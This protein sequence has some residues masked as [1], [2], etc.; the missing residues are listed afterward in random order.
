MP[1]FPI[2]M[3]YVR[4]LLGELLGWSRK[5]VDALA[6]DNLRN[7]D[8]RTWFMHTPEVAWQ[9]I[10][11]K[12]PDR[13]EEPVSALTLADLLAHAIDP[14]LSSVNT[15]LHQDVHYDWGAARHRIQQ[16][17]DAYARAA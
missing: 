11:E 3:D 4:K 6:A 8:F 12:M 2:Y 17:L 14:S 10:H 16:I 7:P 15:Y 5:K 1:D 9:I 13:L